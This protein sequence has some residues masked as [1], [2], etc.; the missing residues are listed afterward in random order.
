M[1]TGHESGFSN[2]ENQMVLVSRKTFLGSKVESNGSIF[3][4]ALDGLRFKT[5]MMMPALGVPVGLTH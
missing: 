5:S 3:G 2:R 1:K 4:R